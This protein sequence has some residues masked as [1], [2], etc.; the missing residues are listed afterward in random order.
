MTFFVQE[1]FVV[2][3][4]EANDCTT[5]ANDYFYYSLI[6]LKAVSFLSKQKS[7]LFKTFEDSQISVFT[8]H[9]SGV[10]PSHSW[11]SITPLT[12]RDI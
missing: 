4:S 7:M 1:C 3:V 6:Y 12:H 2:V 8:V 10:I 11:L 9:L 5:A